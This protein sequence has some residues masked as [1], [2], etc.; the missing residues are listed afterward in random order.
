MKEEVIT[1]VNGASKITAT[2]ARKTRKTSRVENRL[3]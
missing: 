1:T 2:D 3:V